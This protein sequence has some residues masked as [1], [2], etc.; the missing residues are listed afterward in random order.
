MTGLWI[1]AYVVLP[2]IVVAMGFAAM[3]IAE[4]QDGQ[5]HSAERARD[6]P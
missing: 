4:R 6:A 2:V 3:R 1:Y 5:H